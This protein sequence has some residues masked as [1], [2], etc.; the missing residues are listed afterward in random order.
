MK[1]PQRDHF[2]SQGMRTILLLSGNSQRVWYSVLCL[3]QVVSPSGRP[4]KR[5]F[6]LGLMLKSLVGISI[7]GVW[8]LCMYS[9]RPGK[10]VLIPAC[11]CKERATGP[12]V[13]LILPMLES[14]FV[15]ALYAFIDFRACR[16]L[17]CV[18]LGSTQ[19]V[20]LRGY[21]LSMVW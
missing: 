5:K 13:A 10:V 20:L 9:V 1:N 14:S 21:K 7:G 19:K 18:A 11:S 4:C 3:S 6:G 15:L 8:Y 12:L 2:R 16:P 17:L